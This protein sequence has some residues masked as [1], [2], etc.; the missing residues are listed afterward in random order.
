M[1]ARLVANCPSCGP[2]ELD[3]E[4]V[5]IWICD[6]EEA[7]YY[8]FLC[9]ECGEAVAKGAN[10]EVLDVLLL[11]GA[12]LHAWEYPGELD[13]PRPRKPLCREDVELFM[14]ELEEL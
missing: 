2:V 8:Q 5:E 1:G 10:P 3:P 11:V 14:R 4:E 9:P 13:E 7:S 12:V 6:R